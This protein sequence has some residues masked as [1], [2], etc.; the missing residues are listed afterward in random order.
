MLKKANNQT[1]AHR[2]AGPTQASIAT[3][4][5]RGVP[6]AGLLVFI[7]VAVAMIF[8]SLVSAKHFGDWGAPVN[9][10][11]IPGTSSE[12]N[13]TSND[14]YPILSPDGLSL[15]MVSRSARWVWR[16]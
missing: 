14:G 15:Y 11:S 4:T 5:G 8:T 12:L 3:H 16:A 2:V 9:A 10:E 6:M 1:F 13:T 7:G